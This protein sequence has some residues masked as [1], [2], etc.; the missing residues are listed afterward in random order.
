MKYFLAICSKHKVYNKCIK[1]VK[2]YGWTIWKLM[3]SL[4]NKLKQFA[5][6]NGMN[7]VWD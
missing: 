4:E 7:N 3:K 2:L 6:I 1:S 5:K